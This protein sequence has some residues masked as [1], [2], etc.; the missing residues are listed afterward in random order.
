M[1]LAGQFSFRDEQFMSAAEKQLI[2]NAWITF[3]RRGCRL[4]HFS[5]RLYHHLSLHCSF[6]AH[7]NRHGF[8]E[9][10]FATPSERTYRFLDQFDPS[11]PGIAAELGETYWLMDRATGSDL[12]HAMREVAGPFIVKLRFQLT[13]AEKQSDLALASVLA[14]KHGKRLSE[15]D[16]SPRPEASS[17]ISPD[18]AQ[19]R[20][21]SG[22]QLSM[23]TPV[24]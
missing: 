15:S 16:L 7:F 23:F 1:S 19:N 9:F 8:Y 13:E 6:I 10:Y 18:S 4:E 12:N 5:E 2:L 20:N 22:E 24:D 21:G 11:K 14:A 17:W 3:L